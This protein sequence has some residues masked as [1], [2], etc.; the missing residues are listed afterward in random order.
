MKE[1]RK[2]R[3]KKEIEKILDTERPITIH[4][5][6]GGWGGEGLEDFSCVII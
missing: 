1:K 4:H 3:Q 6:G 5:L 2:H